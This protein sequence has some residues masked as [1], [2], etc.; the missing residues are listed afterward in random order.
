MMHANASSLDHARDD[1][2]VVIAGG[3][4]EAV[5]FPRPFPLLARDALGGRPR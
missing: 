2:E 4:A 5:P 1:R 3:T